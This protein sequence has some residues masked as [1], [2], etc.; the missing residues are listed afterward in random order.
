MKRFTFTVLSIW[1]A[2]GLLSA[3]AAGQRPTD[4][5][6]IPQFEQAEKLYD[7]GL[8]LD[9]TGTAQSK[10][11]A[12]GK[13]KSAAELYRAAGSTNSESM[14]LNSIGNAFLY[15]GN[16]RQA[17][18]YYR[19]ALKLNDPG[20]KAVILANVGRAFFGLGEY[21][22][23]LKYLDDSLALERSANTLN[24][25]GNTYYILGDKAAA[26]RM[27]SDALSL[28]WNSPD[29]PNN[30]AI[31]LV[32]L[33]NVF[34]ARNEF[35]KAL[36]KYTEALSVPSS[37]T[38]RAEALTGI[39]RVHSAAARYRESIEYYKKALAVQQEIGNIAGERTTLNNLGAMSFA[40]GDERS[41]LNYFAQALLIARLTESPVSEAATLNNLMWLWN[42]YKAPQLAI[43]HGKQSVNIYQKL[44]SEIYGLD[45]SVQRSYVKSVESTYKM[46]AHILVEQG[47]L[48][49][50]EQVLEML[51]VEEYLSYL[52]RNSSELQGL[53]E[54]KAS[55]SP[56]EQSAADTYYKYADDIATANSKLAALERKRRALKPGASLPEN[57]SAEQAR[58]TNTVDMLPREFAGF[59]IGLKS[60]F[61]AKDMKPANTPS[62]TRALLNKN[63]DRNTAI[64][65]AFTSADED[66]LNLILTTATGQASYRVSVKREEIDSLVQRFRAALKNPRVDPTADGKQLYDILFPAGLQKALADL[67]ANTIVWSLDGTLRYV[68]MAA[69]WDGKKY[70]AQRYKQAVITLA[71]G[72]KFEAGISTN[73]GTWK[74][75][76]VGTSKGGLGFSDLDSVPRELCGVVNDP[77]KTAYCRSYNRKGVFSGLLLP[78]EEFTLTSFEHNL[79]TASV[80]H[81]AS[82]FALST[83]AADSYLLLGGGMERKYTLEQ[84]RKVPL[85]RVELLTLS[86]CDTAM[87]SGSDLNGVEFESFGAI[88][89]NQG[90]KS[91]LATLWPVADE[92]TQLVMT[93]FYRLK[94]EKSGMS[95]AGALQTAQLA[96]IGGRLKPTVKN[97]GCRGAKPVGG[98]Q[99]FN[100][101]ANAP[102]SHPYYW[103]PFVLIGNWR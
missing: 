61:S 41:A 96:M 55:F 15:L 73:Q 76:A 13:W 57:E 77:K 103:A 91:I 52:N 84:L 11:Q 16:A 56:D 9:N 82:H 35:D 83:N 42:E 87:T 99:T 5:L 70:L 36:S 89:M 74:A 34:Y 86:A 18:A 20:G 79:S 1:L 92:S 49:E 23:A 8:A 43:L 71:S 63:N 28:S 40:V 60:R 48:A 101:D 69:L 90:A 46:L 47:R 102:F 72:D 75:L 17:I 22:A 38:T 67:Q 44:R 93:E 62:R 3:V 59:L 95:K 24:A 14:T 65:S 45:R 32:G 27:Y 6:L 97:A 31:A 2:V 98:A 4:A 78:D 81:I 26:E 39:A 68:P 37:K 88:A 12:I 100:C 30:R 51:K 21:A 54:E 58:L 80:I 29:S 64:I 50:A 7:E 94:K 10:L 19:N 53:R 33:G 25:L 85:E 66:E